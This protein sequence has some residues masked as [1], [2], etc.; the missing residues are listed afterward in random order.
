M[1]AN[2]FVR[3][4]HVRVCTVAIF[5][6]DPHL[7]LTELFSRRSEKPSCTPCHL[8]HRQTRSIS[9]GFSHFHAAQSPQP[10]LAVVTSCTLQSIFRFT[11]ARPAFEHLISLNE[12]SCSFGPSPVVG[13][14]LVR[15][16]CFSTAEV[17]GESSRKDRF[18]ARNGRR[19]FGTIVKCQIG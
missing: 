15:I 4:S 11:R 12:N 1:H 13:D 17:A 19:L 7:L 5:D 18:Q 10:R 8:E 14:S 3:G 6:F 16:F 2:S 9:F